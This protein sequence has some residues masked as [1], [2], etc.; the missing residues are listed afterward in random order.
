MPLFFLHEENAR[1]HDG[2][3]DEPA[4]KFGLEKS[5]RQQSDA[6]S[7]QDRAQYLKFSAHEQP[8]DHNF[9]LQTRAFVLS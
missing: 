9:S 6:E 7:H 4:E 1:H 8:S 3:A 2:N 5:R